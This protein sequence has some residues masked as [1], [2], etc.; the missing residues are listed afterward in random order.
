MALERDMCR[1]WIWGRWASRIRG[2]VMVCEARLSEIGGA[3]I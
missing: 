3:W 1:V 2:I